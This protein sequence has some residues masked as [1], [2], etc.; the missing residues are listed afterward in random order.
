[1][2]AGREPEIARLDGLLAAA[3]AGQGG[4]VV[5][6][7]EPGIGKTR[8][9]EYVAAGASGM[10][11]L[12][13]RGVE[14]DAELPLAGLFDLL[15]PLTDTRLS[16]EHGDLLDRI[17]D[18]SPVSADRFAVCT[19]MLRVVCAAAER[20]PVLVCVDDLHWLDPPSLDAVTFLARRVR[21]DPVAVVVTVR[22]TVDGG[23]D[24]VRIDP[25]SLRGFDE[26][27][28]R[29]LDVRAATELLHAVTEPPVTEDDVARL[30]SVTDGNPLALIEL[31]RELAADTAVGVIAA[32]R[33]SPADL[34]RH[35]LGDLDRAAHAALLLLAL[36]SGSPPALLWRAAAALGVD[37]AAFERLEAASLATIREGRIG[38]THPLIRST[39]LAESA[40]PE[41][42]ATHR[43]WADALRDAVGE[44]AAL[45]W[46]LASAAVGPD[47]AA[48]D[49]LDAA[50]RTAE[51][52]SAYATAAVTYE[53][54]GH[55]TLDDS[56]RSDRL[57]RAGVAARQ[58]GKPAQAE[59][60][61]H[62]AA[63]CAVDPRS[64]ARVDSERGRWHLYHGRI[65]EARRLATRA[66]NTVRAADPE[67]A[68]ELLG[69]AAWA[70]M[71]SSDHLGSIALAR[72]ARTL[73]GPESTGAAALVGLTLGTSLFSVG[74]VAESYRELLAAAAA[75]EEH[76][77]EIDPEYVCFAGVGLAWAGEF[78]RARA[79]L[80][81][82][83]E[84]ARAAS[85]F[86]VL[87][88]ALHAGAYV[89]ART[90]HLLNAYADANEALA[91]AEAITNDLWRYF[92]LGCLAHVEA[93]QGR[94]ED[95]RRHA[96]EAVELAWSLDI[97]YPAPVR[98]ALGLLELALGRPE[99]AIRQLEPVNRGADGELVLGRPT[100]ADVVEAFV[101][102][103][104]PLPDRLVHQL[105]AQSRDER[106]PALAALC[107]RC[108]GLLADDDGF[109]DCF[110]TAARLHEVADNPFALARTWLCHGERLRRAGRRA[111]SRERLGAARERFEKLG[112]RQW[113]LRAEAE[114]HAAG[115]GPRP[116][117]RPA[118]VDALTVQ[119][120]QVAL[121]VSR[122]RT[123]RQV[124]AELYLSPKTIEYHLG[125]VYRKLGI[126]S[127]A[128]LAAHLVDHVAAA[129]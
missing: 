88:A 71:I 1:M 62:E 20:R 38:L 25:A 118:G 4:A 60:L 55:L 13:T 87:C 101:R 61:L 82:V 18:G 86:G 41:V 104:R 93:A 102:A 125:N 16:G 69:M 51:A 76:V 116:S 42:R 115:A 123:N 7:G 22:D 9:L 14:S 29:G 83:T 47:D 8:L 109:D 85:A 95:C 108:R 89:D 96:E 80:T 23:F 92:A 58:A 12:E 66:A 129:P 17:R 21:H 44:R 24:D 79:L 78:R 112:A 77:D 111:E 100:G 106:F 3:R 46:H 43:A 117:E 15:R 121:A 26:V 114:L 103:E 68:A 36:D 126:R 39:V 73:L 90:G 33:R 53:R 94:E 128:G 50:G 107:W 10:T 11:V 75:V 37:A 63:G 91:T 70:A 27:V 30:V 19:A 49:A 52:L 48:A 84:R 81:R 120:L 98:E 59:R 97:G 32:S 65:T 110:R 56:T 5:V 122:D 67:Q 6:R 35:R 99:E 2:L 54:A 34:F 119:E 57:L 113:A 127:R 64:G 74:E 28:P 124:A 45:A 72:E 40:P 105:D 31:A